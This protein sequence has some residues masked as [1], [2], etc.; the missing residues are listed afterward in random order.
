VS[1]GFGLRRLEATKDSGL[2]MSISVPLG[3]P[4]S[5]SLLGIRSRLRTECAQVT[6]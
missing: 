3:N 4:A 2:V 5:I 1:V 6:P